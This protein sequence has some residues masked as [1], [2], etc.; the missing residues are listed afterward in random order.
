MPTKRQFH[1]LHRLEDAFR[2]TPQSGPIVGQTEVAGRPVQQPDAEMFF[3][4]VDI[5]ADGRLACVHLAGNGGQRT[6]IDNPDESTERFD[7]VHGEE[8]SVR[9][10]PDGKRNRRG[11]SRF[12]SGGKS[13]RHEKPHGMRYDGSIM[14]YRHSD[15]A[16]TN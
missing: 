2:V 1:T 12:P 10:W 14:Q 5:P 11:R 7:C 13:R 6:G 8:Y 4:L 15:M 9:I 16:V 3:E